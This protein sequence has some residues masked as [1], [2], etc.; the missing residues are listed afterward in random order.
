MGTL[1]VELAPGEQITAEAGA[2]VL[3]A[4][5]ISMSTHLNAS[6]TAG[7]FATF[8]AILIA[9]IRRVFGGDTFLVNRF[10]GQGRV[11]F[12]PPLSGQLIHRRLDGDAVILRAGAYL[13]SAG[14]V[15][16]RVRWAGL[17]GLFS[18][19]GLFFVQLSG[20]GDVWFSAYGA[21]EELEVSGSHIIDNGHVLAFDPTLDFA[22][23]NAGSGGLGFL[24]SGEGLVLEF[25]GRGKVWVQTR[26]LEALV[27]WVTP[28]LP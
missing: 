26:N 2:M 14:D 9:L 6:K 13:A 12:A 7:A 19:Q 1:D 27:S 11:V 3:R 28:L 16:V 17:R 15:D 8:K 23:R 10:Q 20:R 22:I 21:V 25:K 4:P 18:K 24:A 5:G